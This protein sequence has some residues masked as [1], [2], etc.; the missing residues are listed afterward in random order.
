LAAQPGGVLQR[1]G[2]TEA[3]V[4]LVRL[5][6]LSSAAA[7]AEILNPDGTRA[8]GPDLRRFCEHHGLP[9]VLVEDIVKERLRGEQLVR[10]LAGPAEVDA[11]CGRVE[12]ALFKDVLTGGSYLTLTT[13][14]RAGGEAALIATYPACRLAPAR[15]LC[16][17]DRRLVGGLRAVMSAGAGVVV[18]A[19]NGQPVPDVAELEQACDPETP[20]GVRTVAAIANVLR[21]LDVTSVRPVAGTP[22]ELSLLTDF[23]IRVSSASSGAPPTSSE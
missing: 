19:S 2:L 22:T 6:G 7:E 17:C 1:P 21:A 8:A 16:G 13:R 18:I 23:G 5:A 20:P 14:G 12:V 11:P 10:K 4:D 9:I 3:S 15:G